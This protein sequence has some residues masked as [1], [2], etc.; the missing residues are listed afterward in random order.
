MSHKDG[1]SMLKD[2]EKTW[3]AS[4]TFFYDNQCRIS[5]E[6]RLLTRKFK[7]KPRVVPWNLTKPS[8][9][10]M[11]LERQG[12]VQLIGCQT[13]ESVFVLCGKV[14]EVIPNK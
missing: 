2:E 12:F 13:V 7:N 9:G 4:E 1:Q 5:L 14:H 8:I 10:I 6:Q 11:L 3:C